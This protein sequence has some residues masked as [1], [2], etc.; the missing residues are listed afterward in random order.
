MKRGFLAVVFLVVLSAIFSQ[1]LNEMVVV[2]Q[3]VL[4][5]DQL[6]NHARKDRMGRVCAGLQLKSTNRV[7]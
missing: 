3:A 5:P 7:A 6:V 4:R 1:I 2:K